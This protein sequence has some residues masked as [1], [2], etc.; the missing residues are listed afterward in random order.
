MTALVIVGGQQWPGIPGRGRINAPPAALSKHH[1]EMSLRLRDGTMAS[2][3]LWHFIIYVSMATSAISTGGTASTIGVS[4]PKHRLFPMFR[5]LSAY[6]LKLEENV[7]TSSG[8]P[9]E[10]PVC[11]GQLASSVSCRAAYGTSW[12]CVYVIRQ[13]IAGARNDRRRPISDAAPRYLRPRVKYR[14]NE[15]R[16]RP[17]HQ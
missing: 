12:L 6:E 5:A 8:S 17:R 9:A 11:G 14:C 16:R 7:A 13:E 2:A 10:W 15:A 3:E 4:S 1:H